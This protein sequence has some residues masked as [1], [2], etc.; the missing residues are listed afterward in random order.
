MPCRASERAENY[1]FRLFFKFI[2][3][4]FL[5]TNLS[6][7]DILHIGLSREMMKM[8]SNTVRIDSSTHKTLQ[9]LSAQTGQKMREILG[10][11]VELYRRQL[12]LEKANAAFAALKANQQAW[13]EE[14]EERAAWD[15]ALLDG[16]KDD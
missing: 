2:F 9:R 11:A 3:D 12:F 16:L 4:T 8:A 13:E 7:A 6:L 5:F 1:R 14:K 15:V 10:E